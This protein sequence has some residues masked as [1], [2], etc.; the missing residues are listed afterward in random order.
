MDADWHISGMCKYHRKYIYD[1]FGV[2]G[3]IWPWI[4]KFEFKILNIVINVFRLLVKLLWVVKQ[5][6]THGN[7][8]VV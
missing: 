7:Q 5:L 2:V 4:F 1:A 3:I 8:Q 6:I